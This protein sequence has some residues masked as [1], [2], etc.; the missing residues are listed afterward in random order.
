MNAGLLANALVSAWGGILGIIVAQ[1]AITAIARKWKAPYFNIGKYAIFLPFYALLVVGV[2]VDYRN[3]QILIDFDDYMDQLGLAVEVFSLSFVSALL[4]FA[5][6]LL[7]MGTRRVR[8]KALG[9]E[10]R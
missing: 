10:H 1:V 6:L 5:I 4:L 7:A 3:E 9:N 2:V 8:L